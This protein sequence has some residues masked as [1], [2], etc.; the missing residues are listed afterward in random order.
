MMNF[1]AFCL[2]LGHIDRLQL[3]L[4]AIICDYDVRAEERSIAK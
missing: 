4:V 3:E 1:Q 2:D